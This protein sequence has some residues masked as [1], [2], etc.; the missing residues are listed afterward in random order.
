MGDA[1]ARVTGILR[2]HGGVDTGLPVPVRVGQAVVAIED[3]RFYFNHGFDPISLV[4][5]AWSELT[6]GKLG[7]GATLSQQLAK[8]LYVPNDHTVGRKLEVAALAVKLEMRYSKPRILEMYLN[9]I[10]YGDGQWG[11]AQASQAYFGK[12]P[13]ALDWAQ[14]SLLAGLPRAPSAYDPLRHFNLARRRQREVLAALVRAG[15]LARAQATAAYA[16]PLRIAGQHLSPGLT[17]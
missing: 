11:I 15:T 5:A 6:T 4:R 16:E 12:S 13:S 1:E 10:Y 8:V 2:A 14:S 3:R 17:S 7:G 9:A